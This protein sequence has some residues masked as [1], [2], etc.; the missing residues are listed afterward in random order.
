MLWRNILKSD[1]TIHITASRR[2][3]GFAQ[4][5]MQC[6]PESLSLEVKRPG[7]E[8]DHSPSSSAEVKNAWS[9]TSTPRYVFM[10]WCLAKHRDNFTRTFIYYPMD[11][12][13]G[14]PQRR[15][16]SGG[17]E[18]KIPSSLFLPGIEPRKHC[19]S[20]YHL[21]GLWYYSGIM[22]SKIL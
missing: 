3:L 9:Y 18:K 21:S 1:S 11:R 17:Q 8:A 22:C 4:P 15:S 5:P 12:R 6:V 7:C 13:L 20:T 16:G 19:Q 10:A 14:G 2:A